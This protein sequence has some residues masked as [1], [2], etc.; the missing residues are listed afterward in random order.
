M[1]AEFRYLC[2]CMHAKLLMFDQDSPC[3]RGFIPAFITVGPYF[4]IVNA[5]INFTAF[6]NE[7]P[8]GEK[9]FIYLPAADVIDADVVVAFFCE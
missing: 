7:L 3:K 5:M 9:A 4:V 2:G 8:S 1:R 6:V